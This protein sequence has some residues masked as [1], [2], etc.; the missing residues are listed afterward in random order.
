MTRLKTESGITSAEIEQIYNNY[1]N[2]GTNIY[3]KVDVIHGASYSVFSGGHY[4]LE[5]INAS[6]EFGWQRATSYAHEK[7]H[8]FVRSKI[9]GAWNEWSSLI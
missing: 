6:S 5:G 3:Y 7:I 8:C 1:G 2:T 4:L 9:N